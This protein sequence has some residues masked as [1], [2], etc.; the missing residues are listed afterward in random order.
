M[1][2]RTNL[3][4]VSKFVFF[5]EHENLILCELFFSVSFF[6][7]QHRGREVEYVYIAGKT[8]CWTNWLWERMKQNMSFPINL[9]MSFPLLKWLLCSLKAARWWCCRGTL[10]IF[11]RCMGCVI[12]SFPRRKTRLKIPMSL[13]MA[14]IN[15]SVT[16]TDV[17]EELKNVWLWGVKNEEKWLKER[18]CT[19]GGGSTCFGC[20]NFR[21]RLR[22]P[23][24]LE[25]GRVRHRAETRALVHPRAR[26]HLLKH[27]CLWEFLVLSSAR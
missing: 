19:V 9:P 26:G 10:S 22:A 20:A 3:L 18:N 11:C 24:V 4:I 25:S 5:N 23:G 27:F 17:G 15:G 6:Q 12:G 13:L 1:T 8:S 21:L 14:K 2:L 7:R 16:R